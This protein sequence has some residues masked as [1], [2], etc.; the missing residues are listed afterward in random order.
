MESW[1]AGSIIKSKSTGCVYIVLEPIDEL[2]RAKQAIALTNNDVD[3]FAKLEKVVIY[4]SI[5]LFVRIA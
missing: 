4:G 2:I 1:P 3:K 5:F